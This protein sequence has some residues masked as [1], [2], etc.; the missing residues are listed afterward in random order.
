MDL[1]LPPD[2]DVPHGGPVLTVAARGLHVAP[3]SRPLSQPPAGAH[4]SRD[5]SIEAAAAVE[6]LCELQVLSGTLVLLVDQSGGRAR[7]ALLYA[8]EPPADGPAPRGRTLYCSPP[9]LHNLRLPPACDSADLEP[10]P[11]AAPKDGS[12]GLPAVTVLV[13]RGACTAPL[14]AFASRVHVASIRTPTDDLSLSLGPTA[15]SEARATAGALRRHFATRRFYCPGDV[16]VVPPRSWPAVG[17]TR[18]AEG[19]R[20]GVVE[21]EPG[22][23]PDLADEAAAASDSDDSDEEGAVE[24]RQ[25]R[26]FR[27]E[28]IEP[29]G[30]D[31][32][33]A[34][35]AGTAALG[36]ACWQPAAVLAATG[37][38]HAP[39]CGCASIL[40]GQSTLL[41]VAA[42]RCA[43]PR[44]LRTFV[45]PPCAALPVA[46]AEEADT[47]RSHA[48][49]G[50]HPAAASLR[51]LPTLLLHA[52]AVSGRPA[53]RS[54]PH[55]PSPSLTFPRPRLA[56]LPRGRPRPAERAHVCPPRRQGM[57]KR[58]LAAHVSDELGAHLMVRSAL[59]LLR[60]GADAAQA[61]HALGLLLAEARRCAPCVLLLR[62][63]ELLGESAVRRTRAPRA[64]R[65]G[66]GGRA[67]GAGRAGP[68]AR[69]VR[70]G[71]R[72]ALRVV[73]AVCA[74]RAGCRGGGDGREAAGRDRRCGRCMG[75]CAAP[76]RGRRRRDR[77]A[78]RCAHRHGAQPRGGACGAA[79]HLPPH[80]QAG[81]AAARR[82]A[83][84]AAALPGR[85][86][87][88]SAGAR[89]PRRGAW[90]GG[91]AGGW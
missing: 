78:A 79:P 45:A 56:L 40:R 71:E 76:R 3:L 15:S 83:L 57:G 41:Q 73:S 24:W 30:D 75:H 85:P 39:E 91:G 8:L 23:L 44:R 9:L 90:R 89:R 58:A 1:L 86:G 64:G 66:G 31:S 69:G 2:V 54:S 65:G 52:P 25:P 13:P 50:L 14:P 28:R 70:R 80:P 7:P 51:L 68:L 33:G 17:T 36:S 84:G 34:A 67:G 22:A 27:V 77:A 5:L 72:S 88:R 4:A 6:T 43:P 60:T 10:P 47:A 74:P 63:L 53:P 42:V 29:G 48:R 82:A 21:G 61:A 81:G 55:L 26:L 46:H 12:L 11:D 35:P 49:L 59:A 32:G 87:R 38:A 18:R 19:Q 62:R 37:A 16:F 20:A